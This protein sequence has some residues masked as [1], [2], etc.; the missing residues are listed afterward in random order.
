MFRLV[1]FMC[2][3]FRAVQYFRSALSPKNQF[4][5]KKCSSNSFLGAIQ[6]FVGHCHDYDL[7]LFGIHTNELQGEFKLETTGQVPFCIGCTHS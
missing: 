1:P 2:S 6:L 7:D 4:V 3:H 5:G